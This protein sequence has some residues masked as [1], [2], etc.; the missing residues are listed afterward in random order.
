[1]PSTIFVL[2]ALFTLPLLRVVVILVAASVL[3]KRNNQ[4]LRL[5]SW[6]PTRAHIEFSDTEGST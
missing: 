2:V 5:V 1:M 4:K 3:A 6:S